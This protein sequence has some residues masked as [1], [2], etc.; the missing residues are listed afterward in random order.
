MR[1]AAICALALLPGCSLGG[2]EEPVP[3]T[4]AAR[5]IGTLVR[6]LELATRRADAA[7][8]CED[9][10]TRAARRRMGEGRCAARVRRGL[11]PLREPQI[12]LRRLVLGEG[13]ARAVAVL[14]TE[15]AGREPVEERVALRLVRGE[16]RLESLR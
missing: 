10:L 8:V 2:D 15:T 3:A 9:L 6:Q 16:W 4:G 12:E 7:T 11:R 1:W 14:R 5:E 13:G